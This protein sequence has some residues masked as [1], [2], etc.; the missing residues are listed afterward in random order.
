MLESA[1]GLV[2]CG[3]CLSVFE[4]NE[5]FVNALPPASNDETGH[6]ED[7]SVFISGQEDYFDPT[8]FLKRSELQETV[9]EDEISTDSAGAESIDSFAFEHNESW[10]IYNPG[11]T[12]SDT[13]Q[14]NVASEEEIETT[15]E[16][17]NNLPERPD[18][19]SGFADENTD[20]SRII[21]PEESEF[22]EE[23][24]A[25]DSSFI[26]TSINEVASVFGESQEEYPAT[27]EPPEPDSDLTIQSDDQSY[28]VYDDI[29]FLPVDT[30]ALEDDIETEDE[31]LDAVAQGLEIEKPEQDSPEEESKEEIRARLLSS[32]LQDS[33][34]GMEALSEEN[35]AAISAV[36]T[37]LELEQ[38]KPAQSSKR[39]L[40]LT[41]ASL[42]L[43]VLLAG[44]FYWQRMSILSLDP[45]LRPWYEMACGIFNC[46]LS[47]L[48]DL[49]RIKTEN[50]NIRSH[51]EYENSLV[52]TAVF[53]NTAE[54]QQPFPIIAIS[55]SDLNNQPIASRDFL[56]SEYLAP[57][58]RS[59]KNMP[60]GSP[61]QITIELSDPGANAVNYNLNFK[62]FPRVP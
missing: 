38:G 11:T 56:P 47:P 44:Q 55:F 33:D 15:P 20:V 19:D 28:Y 34:E 30:E 41:V 24:A 58:L 31:F 8:S 4:A 59:I 10:T 49:T 32:E 14:D 36:D 9:A 35:L 60:V 25:S 21:I 51:P 12:Q 23:S 6:D 18:S 43:I 22:E 2:R 16:P 48:Q 45:K 37:S 40:A 5:N 39:L 54:F 57:A 46:Q 62:P 13:S 50:L 61:V 3:A 52:L 1:Q 27:E 7:N 26:I 53:S 42:I 29:S 17:E